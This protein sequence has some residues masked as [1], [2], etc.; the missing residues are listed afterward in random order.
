MVQREKNVFCIRSFV[1]G[2]F[3]DSLWHY[4][5][6]IP[7]YTWIISTYNL[8][9]TSWN[10]LNTVYCEMCVLIC[11]F[12]LLFFP[13][14]DPKELTSLSFPH[15]ILWI[16]LS[17]IHSFKRTD[18]SSLEINCNSRK[19]PGRTLRF[20]SHTILTQGAIPNR[21][22]ESYWSL[23]NRAY[24]QECVFR[25]ALSIA[26]YDHWEL[27]VFFVYCSSS[28]V[29]RASVASRHSRSLRG[30]LDIFSDNCGLVFKHLIA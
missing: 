18:L 2:N 16:G 11:S 21:S 7:L 23:F 4:S 20:G 28:E 22:T 3:S 14:R 15:R 5:H 24:S 10:I 27:E 13:N 26:S 8:S 29:K 1:R 6:A 12:A 9:F 25:T 30:S 19:S 17:G